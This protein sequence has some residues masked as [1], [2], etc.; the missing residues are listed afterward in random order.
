MLP[1]L[2]LASLG[3]GLGG[4]VT[5]HLGNHAAL[6][7][8]TSYLRFVAPGVLCASAMQIGINEGSWPVM[9]AIRWQRT[10]HAQLATPLRIVEVL[11]GHLLWITI[12]IGA[13]C[14]TFVAIAAAFGAQ[15][16]VKAILEV[17]VATVLGMAFATPMVALSAHVKND[18]AFSTLNRLVIVP[19]FLFSG[20]F[21]PVSELPR[22]LRVLARLT[23]LENGV[24]L[25]RS[26]ALGAGFSVGQLWPLL[27]L[28]ALVIVG[29]HLARRSLTARLVQ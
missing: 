10:Y 21:F 12:K 1:T 24:A 8:S 27:Y 17:L 5:Q 22:P 20:T 6:L 11:D 15:P 26:L 23:P 14:A 28:V 19:L 13:S 7:G 3:I 9:G 2:Y 25:C 4:L 16:S 18:A 29:H